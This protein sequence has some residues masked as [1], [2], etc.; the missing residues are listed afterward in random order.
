MG[1]DARRCVWSAIAIEHECLA[2]STAKLL[3]ARLLIHD[4]IHREN[5]YDAL[6]SD[7]IAS[8]L[9]E[10]VQAYQERVVSK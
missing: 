10:L 3:T 7:W 1:A 9:E 5:V 2:G 8:D 6:L 4:H